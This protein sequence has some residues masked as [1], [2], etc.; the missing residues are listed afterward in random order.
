M[1]K[2]V[3]D[4]LIEKKPKLAVHRSKLEVM[5]PGGYIIHKSW[6]LGK[7]ESYDTAIGKMI[8]D[9]E[10]DKQ[11]HAMD[12][13]F[14]VDKIDVIPP[15]HIIAQHRNN[16][17][18]IEA[19]LKDNPIEIITRILAQKE[20]RQASILEIEKI[21]TYLLGPTKYKKWWNA[22]KKLLVK[23]PNIGVPKKKTEPYVLRD[24]PIT[25]VEEILEEFRRIH[26]P[27]TKI[28]LAEKLHN[29]ASDQEELQKDLPEIL[30]T[31]TRSIQES[32]T[33]LT[34][35]DRLHGVWV[36]NNLARGLHED[37]EIL[38][39]TSASIIQETSSF[40]KLASELPSNYYTRLIDLLTRVYPEKW[41]NIAISLVKEGSGKLLNDSVAF[42]AANDKLDLIK[43]SLERWVSEQSCKSPVLL[44]IIKQ[45]HSA[46]YEAILKGLLEPKLLSAIFYAI[47]YE[48]LQKTTNKRIPLADVLSDDRDLIP[49]LL[50]DANLETARDLAQSLLSNQGFEELTKKSI[51]ARFIRQFPSIQELVTGESKEGPKN[52]LIISKDSYDVRQ[53]EYQELIEVKIPENKEAIAT[54]REHG[55]LRENAEYKM[56]RED[57]TTLMA[58]KA[59]LEYD[60]GRS[61]ITDF[62]GVSSDVVGIGSVVTLTAGSSGKDSTYAILG[63]WDSDPDKNILSYKTPLGQSLLGS[64]VGETV[65]IEI[66]SVQETWTIKTISRW[67]DQKKKK[68]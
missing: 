26:N 33:Q 68:K 53:K 51:L 52:D 5:Q 16:K 58:R 42:L 19:L 57:Q 43:E 9:F 46:K 63:A 23:E 4:A 7:I 14:F 22:T 8:I 61:Q 47:D 39:P 54:A 20:A 49:D 55:D 11:G 48:A 29:L 66:D 37:V 35:A 25:P 6:G 30:E 67:V 50:V 41:E 34:Q 60:L 44:W 65:E 64:S 32:S 12:P 21:L 2:E 31:L 59:Q 45:R 36:R 38:E 40:I 1:D 62:T 56:A 17:A 13:A 15:E 3:I 24:V 27:L 18:E 28:E 10:K